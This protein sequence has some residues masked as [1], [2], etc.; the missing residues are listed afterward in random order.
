MLLSLS[1]KNYALINELE[2]HFDEGLTIITGETG[3]GKSIILGALGLVLGERADVGVMKNPKVNT[4]VEAVFSRPEVDPLII[5]RVLT[6]SGKS[7]AFIDDEPVSLSVLKDLGDSLIDIHSQHEHLLLGKGDYPLQMVDAFANGAVQAEQYAACYQKTRALEA[8]VTTLRAAL[9]EEATQRDYLAFQY[10]Q[11]KEA[12]L[13]EDEVASLEEEQQVLSHASDI[14]ANLYQLL[15][16][17]QE[18]PSGVLLEMRQAVH[19]ADD[20]C[21]HLAEFASL[22]QR[23]EQARIELKDIAYECD[24]LLQRTEDNPQRLEQVKERLDLLYSLMNKHHVDHVNELIALRDD[25]L[26]RLN[27]NQIAQDEL[28]DLEDAYAQA[29]QERNQAAQAW[30]QVRA[31]C[32]PALTQQLK[33]RLAQLGMPHAQVVFDIQTRETYGP[34][35]HTALL[36]LFSANKDMPVRELSKV[37]SG[38]ELSRLMLCIKSLMAQ[39]VGLGT[40]VFDEIDLG[41]SG[42]IASSMGQMICQLSQHVQVLAIT[43]LPQVAAKGTAHFVVSKQTTPTG[44]QTQVRSLTSEERVEEVARMLSGAVVT[45]AAIQNAKE[46]LNN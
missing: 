44:T 11:L 24:G 21:R 10:N 36:F 7:R 1:I 5:R 34:M 8:R 19:T 29:V 23:M 17:L 33:E 45:P 13:K 18:E 2:L 39:N 6:P 22:A 26:R 31:A 4:V 16:L 27:Y 35:G 41:V 30:H 15:Q 25:L 12:S 9:Q 14:R 37:A 46:L 42:R 38:G 43:H 28:R 20:L 32:L 3:A 40:L